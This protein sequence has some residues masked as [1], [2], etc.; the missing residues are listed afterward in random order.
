MS[1]LLTEEL[2]V[3]EKDGLKENFSIA[4][5]DTATFLPDEC[6]L[7]SDMKYKIEQFIKR[8]DIYIR[9]S[10]LKMSLKAQKYWFETLAI[11][12]GN[13]AHTQEIE[14]FLQRRIEHPEVQLED[15]W[16][17]FRTMYARMLLRVGTKI[18]KSPKNEFDQSIVQDYVSQFR[19][20][21]GTATFQGELPI[22]ENNYFHLE[23]FE[24]GN[25]YTEWHRQC[26]LEC[27]FVALQS[28]SN[29]FG[30]NEVMKRFS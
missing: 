13:K 24:E 1:K 25:Q 2:K 30:Y 18:I 21:K 8:S 4:L 19:N 26:F 20:I 12:L 22:I 29:I 5:L 11:R 6:V 28:Y 23:T 16:N 7:T 17:S 9:F 15:L 14:N 27:Y 10:E 3:L